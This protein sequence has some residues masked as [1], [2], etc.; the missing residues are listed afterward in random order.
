MNWR[1]GKAFGSIGRHNFS[2]PMGHG[3]QYIE[4]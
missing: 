3:S 2:G 1:K 4:V